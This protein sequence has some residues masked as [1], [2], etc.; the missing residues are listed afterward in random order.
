[1]EGNRIT[2]STYKDI[3]KDVVNTKWSG[4][5]EGIIGEI[6]T[7]LQNELSQSVYEWNVSDTKQHIQ[8]G[9]ISELNEPIDNAFIVTDIS[10]SVIEIQYSNH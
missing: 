5:L 9:K 3:I 1:L 6:D 2:M 4:S 7:R 10:G 8:I